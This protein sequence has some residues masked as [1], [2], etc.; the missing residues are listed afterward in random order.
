MIAWAS[1]LF[2]FRPLR[3]FFWLVAA[4]FAFG[5][6][7]HA[8]NMLSLSGFDWSS[9][10]V[11][12][13]ALDVVFLVL[14]A[15]VVLGVIFRSGR[16]VIAFLLAAGLQVALYGGPLAAQ[17]GTTPE[18]AAAVRNLLYLSLALLGLFVGLVLLRTRYRQRQP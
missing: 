3:V 15:T 18:N 14:N 9:S 13:R 12:W 6:A 1:A 16:A 10:P 5:G 4:L 8:A 7:V 11:L 2:G 17:F